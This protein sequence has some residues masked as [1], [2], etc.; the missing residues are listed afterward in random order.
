MKSKLRSSEFIEVENTDALGNT[1]RSIFVPR[2]TSYLGGWA[3]HLWLK[4]HFGQKCSIAS[5]DF[6]KVLVERH[7]QPS[8]LIE[9]EGVFRIVRGEE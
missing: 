7:G 6:W 1:I 4:R 2:P 5:P 9:E 8:V 3:R